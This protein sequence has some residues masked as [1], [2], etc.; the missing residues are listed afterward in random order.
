MNE[1]APFHS[2]PPTPEERE[3]H[4]AAAAKYL[5]ECRAKQAAS[6]ERIAAAEL[7]QVPP[8][9]PAPPMPRPPRPKDAAA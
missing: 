3:E 6:R 1:L 5:P 7:D 2:T 4:R 9:R 8:R